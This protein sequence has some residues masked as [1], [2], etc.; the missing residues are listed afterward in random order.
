M[1]II[2][3][4][5]NFNKTFLNLDTS[6]ENDCESLNFESTIIGRMCYT[7]TIMVCRAV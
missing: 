5:I 3:M 7:I 4:L 1:L 2:I 6:V